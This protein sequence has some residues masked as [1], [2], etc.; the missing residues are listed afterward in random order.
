[1]VIYW[2]I[3]NKNYDIGRIR[4]VIYLLNRLSTPDGHDELFYGYPSLLL[5]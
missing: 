3:E 2:K 5:F 1:M 4:Q